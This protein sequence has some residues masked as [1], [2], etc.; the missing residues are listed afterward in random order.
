MV[1]VAGLLLAATFLL[2][3]AGKLFDRTG[4]RSALIEFDVPAQFAGIAARLLPAAELATALALVFR[5]SARIGAIA[6]AALLAIFTAAIFRVVRAG[7]AP[8][9]HC[10]GQLHS[11]PAGRR[12]LVRNATLLALAV[13]ASVSGP[14][15]SINSLFA[16]SGPTVPLAAALLGLLIVAVLSRAWF[17]NGWLRRLARRTSGPRTPLAVGTPA[18]AFELSDG[19]DNLIALSNL[20]HSETPLMLLFTNSE[21]VQCQLY[22]PE[23]ARWQE[24]LSEAL[25]IAPIAYGDRCMSEAHALEHGVRGMLFSGE[26]RGLLDAYVV[27]VTPCAI[28]VGGNGLIASAP[29]E[30]ARAI[31]ALLRV[32]SHGRSPA[33]S[34]RAAATTTG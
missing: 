9:C 6:A 20:L 1:A 28:L 22:M 29:I 23:L 4:T 15:E 14:G 31:D 34:L 11:A 26:D 18:P 17:G 8:D 5:P 27:P 3:A 12:A 16:T 30:G 13:F 24:R 33:G 2:A 25:T 32:I 19:R 7:R 10:F 21:C